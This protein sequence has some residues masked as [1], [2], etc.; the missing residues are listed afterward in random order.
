MLNDAIQYRKLGW[1]VIPACW[2][3]GGKCG[4]GRNH[5]DAGKQPLVSWKDYQNR[6][7]SL[8]EIIQWWSQWP[9]ANI[10]CITGAISGIAVVDLEHDGLAFA[11]KLGLHS[12]LISLTGKGRHLIYKHP[13]EEVCN[14]AKLAGIKGLDIRGDGGYIILPP[15]LHS[16]GKRYRWATS[17]TSHLLP[18]PSRLTL[19]GQSGGS[20]PSMISKVGKP[21]G[22]LSEALEGLSH[23]NRNNT[24]AQVVGRLHRDRWTP[25]DIRSLLLPHAL[26]VQFPEKEL[27]VII[28]SVTRYPVEIRGSGR[29]GGASLVAP[30]ASGVPSVSDVPLVVRRLDKDWDDYQRRLS[31]RGEIE[32]PT[33]YQRL[34]KLTGGLQR[35]EL[36]TV[37]ARTETG[38]TNWILRTAKHL[39]GRNR[40]VLLLSTEMSY[41][42]IWN[43]YI[44]LG[45]LQPIDQA[46]F[47]VIDDFKPDI[48]RITKSLETEKPD[49]F[50]FD[51]IN[52]V[53][54]ENAV[55]SEF[56]KGL[57]ELSRQ[58]NIPGIVSAQLNRQADWVDPQTKKKVWPRMSMIKGSG[59][60]EET[61]AQ[62]LLLHE[63]SNE[64]DHKEILGL[65]EKNRYGEKENVQ[66]I[67]KK[68]PYRMEETE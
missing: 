21:A 11:E 36:F 56:M 9:Q 20:S 25:A 24:F 47:L 37:A 61:S 38:K 40:R 29:F 23:G 39:C 15:S 46:N 28:G 14:R 10:A 62:V 58:F 66:F 60:I 17:I 52:I 32:F 67:L 42:R 63:Q 50:I 6:L 31:G 41:E 18:F 22:W 55:I 51:H 7:P 3:V 48:P 13:G 8:D 68:H 53:G 49:V 27:D 12:S 26:R 5:S 1:S 59:T 54:D 44:P 2:P 30:A 19:P 34:D 35:G 57:K 16:T 64:P 45:D 43:R 4:C 65:L 33:G